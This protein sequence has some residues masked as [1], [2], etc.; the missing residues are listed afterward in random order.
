MPSYVV[1]SYFW[2]AVDHWQT[3]IAGVFALIAGGVA[4]LAGLQQANA[5]RQAANRQVEATRRA[6]EQEVATAN[7]ELEHLKAEKAG[8]STCARRFARRTGH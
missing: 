3:L 8:G 1:T 6:A 4:Y 2:Q 7:A 5:T